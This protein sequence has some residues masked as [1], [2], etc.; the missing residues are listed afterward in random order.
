M[1]D[2]DVPW[3][4]HAVK[5][6]DA[7]ALLKRV[8]QFGATDVGFNVYSGMHQFAYQAADELRKR[9]IKVHIG[10]PHATYFADAAREHADFV[11]KGQS[12]DSF[13]AYL[14]DNLEG[15]A[16]ETVRNQFEKMHFSH[17]AQRFLK[18]RGETRPRKLKDD[19]RGQIQSRLNEIVLPLLTKPDAQTQISNILKRGI[20]FRD[21]LS[22]TFP[23]PDR[24]TFYKDN[25]DMFTNPI[26]NSICG[27]GCPFACTYCYNVAWNSPEMYGRFE[28]RV[29]RP[30]DDM[31]RELTQLKN[32]GNT[33]LIYFQDDVFGF[34]MDWM[35]KFMPLYR[36]KV[37]V[38]FH[39]QLRLELAHGKNGKRRLEL[40]KD[41]G[42][43]GITVAIESGN[44]TVRK[45][46]LDRAMQ[47]KHIFEGCRNIRKSELTLRT[48]QI[49]AVP[50]PTT[51]PGGSVI[52]VDLETLRVNVLAGATISWTAILAPYGGTELGKKCVELGLYPA[53]KLATNNDIKDSFFDES[54]LDYS[55]M[56]KAQVRVL[57]RLFSSFA[58]Y[59]RGHEVAGRF[60]DY[61]AGEDLQTIEDF[62]VPATEIGK[63]TKVKLYDNELY[64]T[65]DEQAQQEELTLEEKLAR[66]KN[67]ESCATY[68]E[69]A[70]YPA[71]SGEVDRKDSAELI[72]TAT[73]I[74]LESVA[75]WP[76]NS[77]QR[78]AL[79]NMTP[80]WNYVPRSDVIASEFLKKFKS[81][82]APQ[83]EA[84]L[85]FSGT[86]YGMMQESIAKGPL[87]KEAEM[88]R[89]IKE[90]ALRLGSD[91]DSCLTA[92]EDVGGYLADQPAPK[93]F[94]IVSVP[95]KEKK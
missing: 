17:E 77:E 43:T 46:I 51:K 66:I 67:L 22:D 28:R 24:A 64:H 52:G 36:E 10:G 30:L 48:E 50:E 14:L 9:G 33:K 69:D 75:R 89:L 72:V 80:L 7:G 79:A 53:E 58:R 55:P 59:D 16:T 84:F 90:E 23:Q 45:D 26:K 63:I 82:T 49:L 61:L 47:D 34:E 71:G 68:Q 73:G 60:L 27:E 54:A 87:D 29:I 6:Y 39:A 91:K 13:R 37:G 35:E 81:Y 18:A 94:D 1:R 74:T 76:W 56:Y 2:L 78:Q 5:K 21:Y 42:C 95:F 3:T 15:Y 32:D 44:Y 85:K 40:M 70:T 11:Y 38:P 25:P 65:K 20:F 8:E 12:F 88:D 92:Q 83:R 4:F 41:A 57:Q 86:L 93:G 31:I 19:E 62:L